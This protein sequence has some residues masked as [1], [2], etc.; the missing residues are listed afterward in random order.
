VYF[1]GV[2]SGMTTFSYSDVNACPAPA[3]QW[4]FCADENGSC[5]FVGK[6]RVR[7]GKRGKYLYALLSA[8]TACSAAS[9]GGQDPLPNVAKSCQ[10]SDQL[11]SDCAS[12]G[13][14]CSFTGMKQ[15]RFGANGQW[16]T[17]TA[18]GG[19]PC[20]AA[21]FGDPLPN[22]SKRCEVRDVP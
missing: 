20:T 14:T 2:A 21:V 22:V 15:V 17:L 13:A 3:E 16:R 8:G 9:L 11:Y 7:F 4:Q 10:V 19:T 1:S 6:K 5:S 18:S 12:E